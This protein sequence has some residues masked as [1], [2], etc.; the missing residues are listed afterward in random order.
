MRLGAHVSLRTSSRSWSSGMGVGARGR[1]GWRRLGL[2]S[3][4]STWACG[5][6]SGG[7]AARRRCSALRRSALAGRLARASGCGW[8]RLGAGL[9]RCWLA[10]AGRGCG[11]GGLRTVVAVVAEWLNRFMK[12]TTPTALSSVARQV[13]VDSLRR[14]SSRCARSRSRCLMGANETGKCVKR[15]PRAN[16]GAHFCVGR[17]VPH[18]AACRG[19]G[20]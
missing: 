4:C 1:R 14:P 15:P 5:W 10:G 18:A 16:Q 9:P 7:G 2:G 17:A 6:L 13:S 12:P 19:S 11:C 20:A 8:G 3:A